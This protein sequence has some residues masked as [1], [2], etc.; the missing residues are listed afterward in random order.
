MESL[1]RPYCAGARE[2]DQRAGLHEAAGAVD[3][4]VETGAAVRVAHQAHLVGRVGELAVGAARVAGA[5][6]V[7]QEVRTVA[8]GTLLVGR[9][10]AFN[11]CKITICAK[12]DAIISIIIIGTIR[13]TRSI[14]IV[15][16][17]NS[18][19][20]FTLRA[21]SSIIETSFTT[22]MTGNTH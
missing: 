17:D 2:E 22:F 6:A 11:A 3:G 20:I 15:I 14:I 12:I 9:S 13:Q 18:S 21:V 8:D 16:I 7:D 1:R 5:G 19:H 10:E 4:G